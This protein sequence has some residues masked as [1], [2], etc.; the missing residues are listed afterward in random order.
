MEDKAI[1]MQEAPAQNE[2]TVREEFLEIY[3]TNVMS[4]PGADKLL[5]YL[6]KSDFFEA[7]ASTKYHLCVP[8]GLLKHS[9]NVYRR[10]RK[11]VM[12]E[13]SA[14]FNPPEETIAIVSL[15]HD[16]CKVQFYK[17][18]RKSR[19]TGEYY[20]NGKPIWE[21]YDS[22]EI[23]DNLPYGHGEKSVYIISGYIRLTREEAMAIRW[24]MGA[25]EDD[26][27][28]TLG[29]AFQMHRLAV[30]LHIA[31]MQATYLDEAV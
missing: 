6:E 9:V 1:A 11:L 20:P 25:W 23:E 27:K 24:H 28:Q 14:E 16:L 29:K 12:S 31:D 5:A 13:A 22:Y 10:L 8:G 18:A 15:L 19:K 30:L 4:R 21:D 26:N 2:K 17:K 7:P 3:N